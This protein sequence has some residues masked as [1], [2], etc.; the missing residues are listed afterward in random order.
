LPPL[1]EAGLPGAVASRSQNGL[2]FL[3]VDFAGG[4]AGGPQRI[5]GAIVP[6]ADSTWF[7]KLTG[8][9]TLVAR[10]KADFLSFLQSIKPAA[11]P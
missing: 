11:Q 8:P 1:D 5:L 10:S 7:F 4:P 2:Q 3:V 6:F 9:D